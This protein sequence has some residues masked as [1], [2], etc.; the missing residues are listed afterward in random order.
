MRAEP[1][2]LGF[3]IADGER[4]ALSYD[5]VD[6]VFRFVDWREEPKLVYFREVVAF[7]WQRAELVGVDERFDAA[8]VIHDSEWLAEHVRQREATDAHRHLK[9]NFNAAGCFEIICG[10]VEVEGTDS[11]P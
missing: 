2:S 10:I 5:G 8:H 6:V 9:P 11:P 3:T 1:V 7:K 4:V